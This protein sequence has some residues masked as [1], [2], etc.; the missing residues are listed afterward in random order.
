MDVVGV[1]HVSEVKVELEDGVLY[2]SR[3]IVLP[4]V[5]LQKYTRSFP[6]EENLLDTSK[7]AVTLVPANA[8]A[9]GVSV[10]KFA[11]PKIQSTWNVPL[12]LKDDQPERA[13]SPGGSRHSTSKDD[14]EGEPAEGEEGP[15]EVP[16][17]DAAPPSGWGGG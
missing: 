14:E 8:T 3:G 15:A 16:A 13:S 10:L 17:E 4:K 11:L 1:V 5:G 9:D 12:T 2:I 7:I 6:F